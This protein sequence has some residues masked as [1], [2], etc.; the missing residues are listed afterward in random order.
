MSSLSPPSLPV[1]VTT[2]SELRALPE[3][4]RDGVSAARAALHA[5][6]V[7]ARGGGFAAH[8]A[9]FRAEAEVAK[10]ETETAEVRAR[11]EDLNAR[12]ESMYQAKLKLDDD[13][14]QGQAKL[15]GIKAELARIQ[16]TLG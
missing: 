2:L 11:F 6:V 9:T 1:S 7:G 5:A 15:D 10:I 4:L 12:C 3:V 8:A 13:I 16:A 14:Y